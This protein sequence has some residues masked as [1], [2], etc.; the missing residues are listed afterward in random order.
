MTEH[1][2]SGSYHESSGDLEAV[3]ETSAVANGFRSEHSEPIQTERPIADYVRIESMLLSTPAADGYR[4]YDENQKQTCSVWLSRVELAPGSAE[5]LRYLRKLERID[6]I[7]PPIC[8]LSGYGVDAV[9]RAFALF[10]PLDGYKV[11]AGNLEGSEAERRYTTCLRLASILHNHGVSLGDIC[12]DSFWL[13]RE[14]E[15]LMVGLVGILTEDPRIALKNCPSSSLVYVAPEVREKGVF[16]ARSDVFS[17]GVLGYQML[18]REFPYGNEPAGESNREYTP[19]T[20]HLP[21]PPLWASELFAK[22]LALNPEDRYENASEMLRG[23]NQIRARASQDESMPVPRRKSSSAI[24]VSGNALPGVRDGGDRAPA[25]VRRSGTGVPASQV[26]LIIL[27]VVVLGASLLFMLPVMSP[28]A[29]IDNANRLEEALQ[30]SLEAVKN[31]PIAK[32]LEGLADPNISLKNKV[33]Y[34]EKLSASDD[35]FAHDALIKAAQVAPNEEFRAVSEKGILDRARR[36]GLGRAAEQGRLWLR[37]LRAREYPPAYEPLLQVLDSAL[38]QAERFAALRRAY[39]TNPTVALRM[40][41]ALAFDLKSVDAFQPLLAQLVG[42]S[43]RLKDSSARAGI[44]LIMAHPDL[45]SVFGEDVLQFRSE[46]PD[47]DLTWLMKRLAVQRDIHVRAIANLALERNLV[48]PIR[49][50]FLEIVRDRADLSANLVTALVR[51]AAGSL[52]DDDLAAFGRWYDV[53]SEDVL[54]AALADITDTTLARK[55]IETL[56]AK[57]LVKEPSATLMKWV[58]QDQWDEREKFARLVGILGN[59]DKVSNDLIEEELKV[60]D[61]LIRDSDLLDILLDT[62]NPLIVSTVVTKYGNLLGLGTLLILLDSREPSVRIEAIRALKDFNDLGALK[63]IIDHYEK[64]SNPTVKQ[65]YRDT[66]WVIKKRE[67]ESGG[68]GE[69]DPFG[70]P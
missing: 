29:G 66:F 37:T 2:E 63:I 6:H 54:L 32:E 3:E 69:I 45:S 42:D 53:Q 48:S 23:L 67:E 34:I 43:L 17:L 16:D 24:Q 56:A 70:G 15:L 59:L 7:E 8:S 30:P 26:I 35:P 60:L 18:C 36:Q 11:S 52:T 39:S 57:S 4:A 40:A 49:S 20:H 14:G 10:P 62:D 13:T 31:E 61:S 1:D 50:S 28:E 44:T 46:V 41:T 51:G 12:A 19:I 47:S 38:P 5:I 9:G 58:R 64:E 65:V 55:A 68:K 25:I 21:N 22:S 27:I 33:A